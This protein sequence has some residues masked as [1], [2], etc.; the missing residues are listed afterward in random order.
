MLHLSAGKT[1]CV[2]SPAEAAH[3]YNG[4]NVNIP[5][6][7]FYHFSFGSVFLLFPPRLQ[8]VSCAT[9]VNAT[10]IWERNIVVGMSLCV[11][12]CSGWEVSG[13]IS[14]LVTEYGNTFCHCGDTSITL[15][16]W[17]LPPEADV[18]VVTAPASFRGYQVCPL[19]VNDFPVSCTGLSVRS[20]WK[21]FC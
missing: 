2:E 6:V 3:K 9:D 8:H 7:C 21:V 18:F 10:D 12:R 11:H 4:S 16:L 20:R 15:V 1:L 19:R 5:P 13:Y 14:W 17:I